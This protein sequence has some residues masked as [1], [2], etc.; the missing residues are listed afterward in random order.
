[1]KSPFFGLFLIGI[2]LLLSACEVQ[3]VDLVAIDDIKVVKLEKNYMQFDVKARLDNPNA[4][5]IKMMNSDL[6]LFLEGVQVG[7]AKLMNPVKILKKTEKQYSFGV[8]ATDI[9]QSKLMPILLKTALTG[10]LKVQVKGYVKGKVSLVSKKV[11][12]DMKD[13]VEIGKDIKL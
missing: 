9:N 12:I 1:M 2:T 6:D 4:F 11:K 3:E 10:K 5:N 13:T 7:K 8:E